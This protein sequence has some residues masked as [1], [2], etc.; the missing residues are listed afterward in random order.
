MLLSPLWGTIAGA[1]VLGIYNDKIAKIKNDMERILKKVQDETS[2]LN[3]DLIIVTDMTSISV[4][5]ICYYRS[6]NDP[7]NSLTCRRCLV[8]CERIGFAR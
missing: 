5:R 6:L 7:D 2:E 3:A 1:T 4:S 8:R